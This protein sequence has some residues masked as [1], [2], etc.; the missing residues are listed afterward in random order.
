MRR[1]IGLPTIPESAE[2]IVKGTEHRE[3]PQFETAEDWHKED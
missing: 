1:Q 2:E 3:R